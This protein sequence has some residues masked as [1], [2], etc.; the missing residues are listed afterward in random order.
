[1]QAQELEARKYANAP[2]GMNFLAVAY[3]YSTGDIFVDASLPIEDL[4]ADLNLLALRYT[5][6]LDVGGLSARLRTVVPLLSGEW[7]G[8]DLASDTSRRRDITG[9]GDLRVSLEINVY[10]APALKGPEFAGYRPKTVVGVSFGV[11]APMGEYDSDKLINIGSNRWTFIPDIGVAKT[12][13]NWAFEMAA[14]GWLF[15]DNSDF[16]GG[17]R[18]E[19]DPVYALQGHAIYRFRPGFWLAGSAGYADGGR[20]TV[21]DVKREDFQKNTRL[22]LQLVYPL[23][24][25]QGVFFA[26]STGVTTRTGSD[27][28]SYSVGYQIAWG[29]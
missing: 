21:Q 16:F 7:S 22:G 8:K 9:F 23:N 11:I 5:R 29:G 1:M 25:S 12:V 15:T 17:Q 26:Y 10:G 6:T 3:G 28:E 27:F 4:D 13:G 19:Q 2:V 14:T 24:R 18:L 20:S